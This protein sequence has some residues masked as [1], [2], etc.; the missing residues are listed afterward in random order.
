MALFGGIFICVGL[1]VGHF[2]Y[3]PALYDWWQS[4]EW[5]EEPCWIEHTEMKSSSSSKG[6]TTYTV[7]AN[8]RYSYRGQTYH[9]DRVGLLSGGDNIGDFHQRAYNELRRF[10]GKETP[11]HCLVNP[12]KPEQAILYRDLRWGLMF[13]LSMFPT[14]FPLIGGLVAFGGMAAAWQV[15]KNRELE[16]LHPGAPWK[17]KPEWEGSEITPSK[18]GL[19]AF[20]AITIWI[21][22]VQLPLSA[23]VILSGALA[24]S[25]SAFAVFIPL[26]IAML[27]LRAAW[28]RLRMQRHVGHLSFKPHHWPLRPGDLLEGKLYFTQSLPFDAALQVKIYCQRKTTRDRGDNTS[29]NTETLWEQPISLSAAL[30]QQ[31][32]QHWLL[33]LRVKL[34][35]DVPGQE[36]QPNRSKFVGPQKIHWLMEVSGET[37]MKP[38]SL[39][40]PVFGEP[41]KNAQD[42]NHDDAA[43]ILAATDRQES[44]EPLLKKYQIEAQFDAQGLPLSI[45]CSSSRNR[46]VAI[47]VLI[48]GGFWTLALMVIIL[49]NAPLL[50]KVIWGLSAPL[51]DLVGVGLLLHQR[52]VEFGQGQF[53][54]I[55]Q[56]GHFYQKTET[57]EP[58]LVLG[59]THDAYMTSNNTAYYRVRAETTYGRHLTLADGITVEATAEKLKQRLQQW[60]QQ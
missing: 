10:E 8:Y 38:L 13:M 1:A 30:A 9:N 48:F 12:T 2:L 33:P 24:D 21:L 41:D 37:G 46:L 42:E 27:L 40:L 23:A 34:S 53:R 60:K 22:I 59:F 28:R 43:Q 57:L 17:W 26:V 39:P 58:H 35:P 5:V 44:L 31:E 50:F 54:V 11:F 49:Q 55:N 4:N 14:I 56:F 18:N 6:S 15:K 45:H 52:R 19:S 36:S 3:F 51:I 47:G 7:K 16:A 20:L 29:T 32:N 25:F